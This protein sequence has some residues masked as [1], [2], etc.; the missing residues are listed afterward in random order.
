MKLI[1]RIILHISWVLTLL[2]AAWA[3]LFYFAMVD[4]INDEVDDSLEFYSEMLITRSL[5]GRELPS[6][7]SGSNNSYYLR[8]VT[9]DYADSHPSV[10]YSDEEIY[11]PE[12]EE[13][14]PARVLRTIFEDC[15]GRLFELTVLT[16]SFEK[17]DLLETILWCMVWLYLLLL[18]TILLVNVLVLH[19]ILRPLYALLRWLD[20]YTVGRANEPLDNDTRVPEF[21][22]LNEAAIRNAARAEY[23]FDRQKQFIGNASHEMQTPLAVCRNRLEMLVDD[24]HALTGEQLGE[25]AK[26]QRT[27]DYLV[28]LNRSLLLL[29]KIDNGQFPEAEEV[30]VNALVRRTAEDMEEIYAYRSMRFALVDEGPLTARMNPSLAGSVVANL[31]K[32]AFVHG[33]EG[34]EVTVRVAPR[35]FTVCN[36]G[37]GGPLDAGRIFDRFYQGTKKEGSTGLGLAVVDAVC[38][39]YGLKVS[40]SYKEGRHCFAVDFPA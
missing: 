28:R 9:S 17:D 15:D 39:L 6:S 35:R 40:Y 37:A 4:E 36:S 20:S 1:N 5:A 38:R 22:R 7:S 18:L 26:V 30:D 13:S 23:L 29:S 25:I 21:R 3:S 11:I 19:R 24:A 12:M 2:L 10:A 33:D 14:E 27:L 31:L 8:E 16:P 32:N 34:G